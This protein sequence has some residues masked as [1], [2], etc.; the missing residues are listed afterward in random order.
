[1]RKTV[2]FLL[3]FSLIGLSY[4]CKAPT[5]V[6][7]E[8]HSQRVAGVQEETDPA[9]S[10]MITEYRG[11]LEEEM[12][13]VIGT[14]AQSLKLQKPESNLGNWMADVLWEKATS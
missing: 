10:D 5:L 7:A 13:T 4:A 8:Q 1:M 11:Q 6:L 3:L 9:L 12:N 2:P 14:V